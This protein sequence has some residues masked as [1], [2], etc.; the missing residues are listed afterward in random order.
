MV[1]II[2]PIF[3]LIIFSCIPIIKD[4]DKLMSKNQIGIFNSGIRTDGYY[5]LERTYELNDKSIANGIMYYVFNKDG[6]FLSKSTAFNFD[7]II[8]FETL[9]EQIQNDLKLNGINDKSLLDNGLYK[10]VDNKISL[11]LYSSYHSNFT[12]GYK[13]V[14][15]DAALNSFGKLIVDNKVYNFKQTYISSFNSPLKIKHSNK[16]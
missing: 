11:Q 16:N 15:I 4:K 14:N 7:K 12:S 5:Y 9:H 3:S 8:H 10:A 6:Y 13:I 1:K 2:F